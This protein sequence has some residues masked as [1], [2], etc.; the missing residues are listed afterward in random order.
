[1]AD[2]NGDGLQDI[3]V[4]SIWG[5]VIW[6]ENAGTVGNPKLTTPKPL[7]VKWDGK[8]PKPEWNWWD[9]EEN[10]LVTQWRTIPYTIDWNGDGLM[11]LIM[12]DQEGY[13]SFFQRI[14]IGGELWLKPGKRIFYGTR[15][16]RFD[17]QHR[18]QKDSTGGPL[19]LSYKK[20]G[21]SGRVKFCIADWNMD[22]KP[23]LLIN[24]RN[25]ALMLNEK[26]EEEKV[27]FKDAGMLVKIKLAGH[28]T[29]PTVVDW[30]KNNTPDLLVGAEDGHF[31]YL[32]N[33][34][35]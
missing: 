13:L 26:R 15:H 3:L 10:T 6:F 19:Q 9:P 30:K 16:S 22:H 17:N 21:S 4:N 33:P 20:Y 12:L 32:Q 29:C 2:W 24:S 14:K 1:V 28:T 25:V 27:Y 11:D 23:D 7:K 31:Y 18:T 8:T 5:K 35:D 34:L